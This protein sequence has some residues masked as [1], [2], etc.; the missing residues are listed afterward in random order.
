M[1][2]NEIKTLC[3]DLRLGSILMEYEGITA[4]NDKQENKGGRL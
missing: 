1:Y 3:K 2:S 4:N